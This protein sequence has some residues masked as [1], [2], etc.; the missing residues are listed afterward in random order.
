M[1]KL[2]WLTLLMV[3][4]PA[5]APSASAIATPVAQTLTAWP[6]ASPYPTYTPYPTTTPKFILIT[7]TF[8]A[9]PL[10]TATITLTP[11]KTFTP[12]RTPDPLKMPHDD[13]NY[14]VGVDIA[15]G[16]WRS[17]NGWDDCYWEIDTIRGDIINNYFGTSGGT[18]YLAPSYFAVRMEDCGAWTFLS[19]P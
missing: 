13:G 4:L 18:M 3:I 2:L 10:A 16:V 11:T 5:C 9:T 6:T 14:L 15:P 17:E 7:A 19:N 1:K 12:T 8:T